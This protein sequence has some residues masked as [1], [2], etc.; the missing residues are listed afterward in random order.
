MK[1]RTFRLQNM[2]NRT[3]RL[4]K[5]QVWLYFMISNHID[6]NKHL[7]D[8]CML[9]LYCQTRGNWLLLL[10]AT[11]ITAHLPS[12]CRFAQGKSKNCPKKNSFCTH[13]GLSQSLS[14]SMLHPTFI[15]SA[16]P[17]LLFAKSPNSGIH[18][19]GVWERGGDKKNN[20]VGEMFRGG[21]WLT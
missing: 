10:I 16:A 11:R 18:L 6:A 12:C 2:K 21:G 9:K 4:Q 15:L 13:R 1:N 3:F 14:I 19:F 20:D 17:K 7:Q 8:N 5:L